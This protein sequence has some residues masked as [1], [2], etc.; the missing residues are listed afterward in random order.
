MTILLDSSSFDNLRS[1]LNPLASETEYLL[2]WAN[3]VRSKV[4]DRNRMIKKAVILK[5]HCSDI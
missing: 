2:R 5:Y 1:K 3:V 4:H